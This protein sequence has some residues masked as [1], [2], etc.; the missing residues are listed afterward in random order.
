LGNSYVP[1]KKY[2]TYQMLRI[3]CYLRVTGIDY[4]RGLGEEKSLL[5]STA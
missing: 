1:K 3:K 2:Q 4:Y 5:G